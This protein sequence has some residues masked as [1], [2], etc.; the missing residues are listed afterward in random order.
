VKWTPSAFRNDVVEL[1]LDDIARL[2]TGQRL[3]DSGCHVQMV[4]WAEVAPLPIS[5]DEIGKRVYDGMAALGEKARR[6]NSIRMRRE[7]YEAIERALPTTTSRG[8]HLVSITGIVCAVDDSVAP[9]TLTLCADGVA[10]YHV[11]VRE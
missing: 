9:Y 4:G 8:I 7:L 6:I 10:L 3:T 2:L 11:W 1:T 5:L